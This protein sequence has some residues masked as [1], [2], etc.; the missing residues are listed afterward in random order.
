M[1][2]VLLSLLALLSACGGAQTAE[3]EREIV[4]PDVDEPLWDYRFEPPPDFTWREELVPIDTRGKVWR[5]PSIPEFGISL[6]SYASQ[7]AR[8]PYG[9]RCRQWRE[10]IGGRDATVTR[11]AWS[12]PEEGIASSF[13][14]HMPLIRRRDHVTLALTVQAGCASAAACDRALAVARTVTAVRRSVP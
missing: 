2:L 14:V 9:N 8:C 3:Q 5:A 11:D 7:P 10:R 13:H 12:R 6:G 4:V 1:R